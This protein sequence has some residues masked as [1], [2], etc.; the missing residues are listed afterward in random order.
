M[1]LECWLEFNLVLFLVFHIYFLWHNC[2]KFVWIFDHLEFEPIFLVPIFN[3]LRFVFYIFH[4]YYAQKYILQSRGMS[5]AKRQNRYK[6][7]ISKYMYQYVSTFILTTVSY[8]LIQNCNQKHVA[9]LLQLRRV[10]VLTYLYT[11]ANM[12]WVSRTFG[13]NVFEVVLYLLLPAI[14]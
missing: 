12:N 4:A 11:S 3:F 6:Y 1:H 8:L 14:H 2:S 13:V 5:V 7:S 10:L 9:H